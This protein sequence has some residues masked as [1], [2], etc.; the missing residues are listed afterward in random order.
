MKT[1]NLSQIANSFH[2]EAKQDSSYR[3]IRR[4]FKDFSFDTSIFVV[5]VLNLFIKDGKF[6]LLLDRTNW[7]WGKKHIN[8]L[9]LSVAYQGISLPLFWI[10][11]NRGGNASLNSRI[12]IMKRAV[13]RFG[14]KRI[15]LLLADREFVGSKWFEFLIKQKIPFV[16]RTKKKFK[17]EGIELYRFVAIE[18]LLQK[19]GSKKKRSNYPILLWGQLVY[20]SMKIKNTQKNL[21]LCFLIIN[22]RMLLICIE[23]DGV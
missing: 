10:V 5:V 12:E 19:M 20:V 11:T 17:A 21:C 7:K 13:K 4:F 2:T 15:E 16:I 9:M 23:K 1:V 14:V 6:T 3:R 22:F 8:I 18:K